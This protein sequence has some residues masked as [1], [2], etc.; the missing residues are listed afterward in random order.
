MRAGD[1]ERG[2]IGV[3]NWKNLALLGQDV[4]T[5]LFPGGEYPV[6]QTVQVNGVNFRVIGVMESKGGGNGEADNYVFVPLPTIQSRLGFT[7]NTTGQVFV[8][9]INVQTGNGVDRTVVGSAVSQVLADRHAVSTPD[10]TMQS[11]ED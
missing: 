9:Q 2:G 6:D 4:Y 5:E 10:F 8:Q 11:Q 1:I 7:R 3:L